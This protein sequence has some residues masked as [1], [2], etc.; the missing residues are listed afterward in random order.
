MSEPS[1]R[2]IVTRRWACFL[3]PSAAVKVLSTLPAECTPRSSTW[4]LLR[5]A[6]AA[7]AGNLH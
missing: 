2:P 5:A 1:F 4:R 3:L 6:G 7:Y